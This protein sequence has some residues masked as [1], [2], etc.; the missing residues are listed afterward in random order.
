MILSLSSSEGGSAC[1]IADGIREKCYN[2]NRET[3]FFDYSLVNMNS[4]IKVLKNNNIKELL[5]VYRIENKYGLNLMYF[6]NLELLCSV[7]D[8]RDGYGEKEISEVIE[9]KKH[10][11]IL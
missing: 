4:I 9:M 1:S 7:H 6:T 11:M 2:G 3:N 10:L 8:L 5:S